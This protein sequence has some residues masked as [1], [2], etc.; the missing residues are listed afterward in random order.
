MLSQYGLETDFFLYTLNKWDVHFVVLSLFFPLIFHSS[1]SKTML[2]FHINTIL[3]MQIWSGSATYT[4]YGI[5]NLSYSTVGS[6]VYK[7]S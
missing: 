3:A 1:C 7:G 5:H 4:V 6:T 2:I